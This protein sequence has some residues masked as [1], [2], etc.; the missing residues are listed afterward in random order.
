MVRPF[1]KVP[2][3]YLS[4]PYRLPIGVAGKIKERGSQTE[5]SLGVFI[6]PEANYLTISL[7]WYSA[8]PDE[9]RTEYSPATDRPGMIV[10]GSCDS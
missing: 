10:A 9:I 1:D 2:I 3:S 6:S 4:G 8:E 7:P 5:A